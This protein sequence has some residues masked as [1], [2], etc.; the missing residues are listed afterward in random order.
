MRCELGEAPPL[1]ELWGSL[2]GCVWLFGCP[3]RKFG[4]GSLA[5][6]VG[7]PGRI[8]WYQFSVEL[9]RGPL[10]PGEFEDWVGCRAV[11]YLRLLP[12]PGLRGRLRGGGLMPPGSREEFGRPSI[13]PRTLLT[14]AGAC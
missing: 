6:E 14:W 1:R 7:V 10:S 3:G 5:P 4:G 11:G 12:G 8:T 2:R 9:C 13:G